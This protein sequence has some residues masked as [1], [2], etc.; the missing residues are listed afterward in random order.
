ME[1][2]YATCIL[3]ETGK[4]INEHNLTAVLEAAGSEV[5]T[6]RVKAIVAA[7]ENT[8]IDAVT[9]VEG[10]TIEANVRDIETDQPELEIDAES[11]DE[12]VDGL[13][14][15]D[16][17]EANPDTPIIDGNGD[18]GPASMILDPDGQAERTDEDHDDSITSVDEE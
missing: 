1:Y 16:N 15:V 9:A 10:P 14:D 6:S 18:D 4:E 2:A 3:N 8:D 7:L 17:D 5:E 11:F 13:S 12:P